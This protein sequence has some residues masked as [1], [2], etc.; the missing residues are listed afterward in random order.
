MMLVPA[1]DPKS[2]GR[3]R[4]LQMQGLQI[5]GTKAM[6]GS[7]RIDLAD[8]LASRPS[9]RA[10]FPEEPPAAIVGTIEKRLNRASIKNNINGEYFR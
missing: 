4:R 10:G 9:A 8:R 1:F 3:T 5:G 7:H 6:S 2:L